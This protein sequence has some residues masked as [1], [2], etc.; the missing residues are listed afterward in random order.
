[1]VTTAAANAT[2]I[3]E[4]SG[5]KSNRMFSACAPRISVKALKI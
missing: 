1:L 4:P 5:V 2:P 3:P